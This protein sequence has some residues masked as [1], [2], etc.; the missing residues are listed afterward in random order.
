ME[1]GAA[2]YLSSQVYSRIEV[3]MDSWPD[4]MLRPGVEVWR[5]QTGVPGYGIQLGRVLLL[6]RPF[7]QAGI[8]GKLVRSS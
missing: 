4:R 2:R 8:R 7:L 3:P 6:G 5:D 1:H